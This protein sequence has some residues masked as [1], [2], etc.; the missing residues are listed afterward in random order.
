MGRERTIEL[1][2]N[3]AL[4]GFSA[5]KI[6]WVRDNEPEIFAKARIFLLPKDYIRFRLTGTFATEVSDASGTSA[7]RRDQ[8][9][10]WSAEM[11]HG[12]GPRP[13]PRAAGV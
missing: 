1:T 7:L 4:T 10:R 13:Q 9:A 6:L 2:C 11:L 5:P 8:R 3:P 12:A